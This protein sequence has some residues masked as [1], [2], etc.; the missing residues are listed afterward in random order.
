[1]QQELAGDAA[2]L[3]ILHAPVGR[4]LEQ[5]RGTRP[6]PSCRPRAA[7]LGQRLHLAARAAR[8]PWG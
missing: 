7:E 2:A 1:M 4:L 6:S 5:G 8:K 3:V